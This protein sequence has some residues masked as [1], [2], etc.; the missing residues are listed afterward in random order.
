MPGD[1]VDA[2]IEYTDRVIEQACGSFVRYFFST[3]YGRLLV[4]ASVVNAV[5]FALA[6]H[7]GVKDKFMLFVVGMIAALGPIYLSS[8]YFLFPKRTSAVL[9]Q[10][11]KPRAKVTVSSSGFG[12]AANGRAIALPWAD[13]KAIREFPDYFLL[14]LARLAFAVIPKHGLPDASQQTIRQV[15]GINA[16]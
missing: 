14:V 10:H 5:G 6:V 8:L 9:K 1:D 3:R 11:L 16:A 7:F 2:E 13:V 15:A 12:I 4:L